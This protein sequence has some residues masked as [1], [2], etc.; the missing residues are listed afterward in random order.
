MTRVTPAMVNES[1]NQT[2]E[3]ANAIAQGAARK[4]FAEKGNV[5]FW[6]MHDALFALEQEQAQVTQDDILG[7]AKAIGLNVAQI[8]KAMAQERYDL[9]IEAD[10]Q[11]AADL[12]ITGTPAYVIG[13]YLLRGA[14]PEQKFRRVIELI[15]SEGPAVS[16]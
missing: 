1:V 16:P 7:H 8:E 11:L 15:L 4:A 2:I 5:G 3:R 13:E 6:R 9:D 14:G 12:G 10:Q